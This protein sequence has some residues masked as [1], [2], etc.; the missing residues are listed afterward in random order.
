MDVGPRSETYRARSMTLMRSIVG[1]LAHPLRRAPALCAAKGYP[2]RAAAGKSRL[3]KRLACSIVH[4]AQWCRVWICFRPLSCG[5]VW[6]TAAAPIAAITGFAYD[7]AGWVTSIPAMMCLLV[8]RQK[9]IVTC[10]HTGLKWPNDAR[11]RI[12][13]P[14]PIGATEGPRVSRLVATTHF[15]RDH[16]TASEG[17]EVGAPARTHAIRW[18]FTS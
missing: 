1:R 2:P 11:G 18:G 5:R 10:R 17:R 13:A 3:V 9:R 4:V 7:D 14:S 16:P 15:W 6:S 12:A 8:A